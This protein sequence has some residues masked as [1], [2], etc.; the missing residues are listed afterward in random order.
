M[1]AFL[2]R[3]RVQPPAE[4]PAEAGPA[5]ISFAASEPPASFSS[6]PRSRQRSQQRLQRKW[7]V[8]EQVQDFRRRGASWRWIAEQLGLA[9]NTV[10]TYGRAPADPPRQPTVRP[11]RRSLLDPFEPYLLARWHEGCQKAT[12]LF[13][14]I[15]AQGYQ[16]GISI[17]RMYCAYLR[18]HPAQA[19]AA[20]PRT[21]RAVSASPRELRW[22]L[23]R[24][25][26]DL[27]TEEQERLGRLLTVSAEVRTLYALLQT[28]LELV[29]ERQHERLRPWMEEAV[30]SGI[31]E[32]QS[33]VTGIE[34]DYA[35]VEAALRLPWSQGQTEG[36]VNK[37]KTLKRQMDDIVGECL[38][39][40]Q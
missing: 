10:R 11:R 29:R 27:D 38:A 12:Q 2:V 32:M 20:Q 36:K 28:F 33:F 15:Q 19:N 40:S 31:A 8:V 5:P 16:G 18:H 30:K 37:L 1:E 6:T 22:L 4:P 9:R 21:Q 24:R 17:L 14:E 7:Q 35:A 3:T 23:G 25:P 34:Q 39:S 13:V 26:E